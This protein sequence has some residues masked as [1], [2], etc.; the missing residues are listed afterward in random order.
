MFHEISRLT[1]EVFL[2]GNMGYGSGGCGTMP[3]LFVGS[4]PGDIAWSDFPRGLT[5]ELY[6]A[7]SCCHDQGLTQRVDMPRRSCAWLEG[8][9]CP[10]L[11]RGRSPGRGGQHL[12]SR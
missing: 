2:D 3:M 11:G 1:I 10:S 5:P 8:D 9:A 12:P 6:Q 7:A 4:D